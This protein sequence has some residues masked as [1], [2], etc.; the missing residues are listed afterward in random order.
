MEP[1]HSAPLC[2]GP[3]S[4]ARD[5]QP[6]PPGP[7][8]QQLLPGDCLL[9]LPP[10]LHP[11]PAPLLH[12]VRGGGSLVRPCPGLSPHTVSRAQSPATRHHHHLRGEGRGHRHHL[13]HGRLPPR[14]GGGHQ[15]R[16][17][18]RGEVRDCLLDAR[19]TAPGVIPCQTVRSPAASPAIRRMRTS[20]R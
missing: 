8:S 7:L 15:V 1:G 12:L 10:G 20:L 3:V 14:G 19:R 2:P 17:S 16:G 9:L 13:L 18:V 4:P 6:P 11:H 5:L